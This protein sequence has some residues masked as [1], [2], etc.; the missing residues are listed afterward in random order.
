MI[1]Q[2]LFRLLALTPLKRKAGDVGD[3]VARLVEVI[4]ILELRVKELENRLNDDDNSN[5]HS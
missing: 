3:I 1:H 2:R 5:S 4:E